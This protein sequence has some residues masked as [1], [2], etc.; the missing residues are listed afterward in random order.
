MSHS[1]HQEAL[2]LASYILG[3]APLK[4]YL[5]RYEDALNTLNPIGDSQDEKLLRLCHRFPSLLHLVDAATA[6]SKRDS[7]IR[8]KLI[9][10]A[11]I[12]EAGPDY[13]DL[14]L[15]QNRSRLYS[16]RSLYQATLSI[17][18]TLFGSVLLKV[19]R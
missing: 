17:L 15:P 2:L 3:Q 9:L 7:A 14:F 19:Y 16:L 8:K 1:P 6:L 10:M 18:N 13:T 12:L 11:A 4:P 5:S